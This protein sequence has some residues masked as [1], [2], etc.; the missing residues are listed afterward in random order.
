VTSTVDPML[1]VSL[2]VEKRGKGGEVV[3]GGSAGENTL[4]ACLR[5]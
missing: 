2:E 5:R 4:A 1:D 3:G